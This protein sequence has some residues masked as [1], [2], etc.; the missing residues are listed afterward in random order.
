MEKNFDVIIVGGG[1]AA[2]FC[3]W[4]ILEKK[5]HANVAIFERGNPIEKRSCPAL[6]AGRCMHCKVCAI[7]SGSGGAGP[8]S[9]GKALLPN[10]SDRKVMGNLGELM[11]LKRSLYLFAEVDNILLENGATDFVT[12]A[13]GDE[14][15]SAILPYA[16]MAKLDVSYR[17][18]RAMGSD[19]SR[20]TF[21]NMEKRL[22]Q[23]GVQFF[24]NTEVV[25]LVIEKN[26]AIG[27]KYCKT[28]H[29]SDAYSE[30][31]VM[32]VGRAGIKWIQRMC[33]NYKIDFT[34][35]TFDFGIRYELPRSVTKE[36]DDA[37]YECKIKAIIEATG[38]EVRSFCHCPK[39]YVSVEGYGKIS[40]VNGQS[41]KKQESRNTNLAILV[42]PKINGLYD[43]VE[44]ALLN[45]ELINTLGKGQPVVQR[46]EDLR[47]FKPTSP[48]LLARNSVR[49]TLPIAVPGNLA[50]GM[51]AQHVY[52]LNDFID[53]VDKII[54]GFAN[55]DN[56]M[57]GPEIKP[58]SIVPI[59]TEECETSVKGLYGIGD[60][61]GPTHGLTP[62]AVNGLYFGEILASRI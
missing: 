35:E 46:L 24:F 12:G 15:I 44:S 38:D 11:N 57:Y 7:T 9:D 51:S 31:V 45:A 56:L 25:D 32:A 58:Y 39:G 2:F 42:S 10:L 52:D 43:P 14:Y 34:A 62:A 61:G 4:K 21:F 20:E 5:P 37:L 53:R 13:K 54:P 8:F 60:G 22:I 6:K 49:P 47:K 17:P 41:L 1:P 18:I 40:A 59:T 30:N 19:G 55:G 26:R 33:K 48:E 28:N 50:L 16:K 36:M 3:A 29:I 27:V 23:K